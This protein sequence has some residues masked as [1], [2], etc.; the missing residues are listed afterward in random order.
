MK[1]VAQ[2]ALSRR[3]KR[4]EGAED[5]RFTPTGPDENNP[6]LSAVPDRVRPDVDRLAL[7]LDSLLAAGVVEDRILGGVLG[8]DLQEPLALDSRQPPGSR[9]RLAGRESGPVGPGG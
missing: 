3:G 4:K 2:L 5:F 1:F 7:E 8:V 9:S 6:I